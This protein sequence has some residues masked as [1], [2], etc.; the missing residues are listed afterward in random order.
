M[1]HVGVFPTR[2]HS[3]HKY[4]PGNNSVPAEVLRG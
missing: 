3:F 4:W 1:M 2:D